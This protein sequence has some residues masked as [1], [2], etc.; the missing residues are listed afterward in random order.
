MTGQQMNKYIGSL[1]FNKS[2]PLQTQTNMIV[3]LRSLRFLFA[4]LLV[5][6]IK[7]NG[8]RTPLKAIP[9]ELLNADLCQYYFL[10]QH[11]KC[12]IHNKNCE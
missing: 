1:A 7:L 4:C 2:L 12:V 11:D 3:E 9:L 5:G 6:D 8:S 10:K